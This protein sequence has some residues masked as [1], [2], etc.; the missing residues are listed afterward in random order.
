[1]LKPN[2]Q[3][4][5]EEQAK[6]AWLD[7]VKNNELPPGIPINPDEVYADEWEGWIKFLGWTSPQS[8]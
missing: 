1:M 7:Y 8:N 6:A 3:T 2:E 4:G 5:T